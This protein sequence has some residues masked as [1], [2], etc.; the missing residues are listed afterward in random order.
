MEKPFSVDI[1][2]NDDNNE[3]SSQEIIL[4]TDGS[5]TAT[6][7]RGK[8]VVRNKKVL[9]FRQFVLFSLGNVGF[10]RSRKLGDIRRL[11]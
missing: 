7:T 8:P 11:F 10:S 4:Q 9:V 6:D 5:N 1:N 3:Q 2:E